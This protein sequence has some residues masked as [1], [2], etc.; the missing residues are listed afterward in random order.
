MPGG[1]TEANFTPVAGEQN[2]QR[3]DEWLKFFRPGT[4]EA[5]ILMP[6]QACGRPQLSTGG[7]VL[8]SVWDT[9][10]RQPETR[11]STW[12]SQQ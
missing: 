1:I 11:N 7:A 4:I 3:H 9:E 12:S 8:H 10:G 2:A 5:D 6:S